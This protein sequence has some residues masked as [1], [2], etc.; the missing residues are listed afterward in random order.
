MDN[1]ILTVLSDLGPVLGYVVTLTMGVSEVL[2]RHY[3]ADRW[4][5]LANFICAMA[6][7]FLFLGYSNVPVAVIVGTIGSLTSMG[8]FSG[9]KKTIKG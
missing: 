1:Q 7:S 3:L 9:V 6:F 4:V 5:P 2:K 8:L